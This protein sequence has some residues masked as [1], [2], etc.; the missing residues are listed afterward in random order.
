MRKLSRMAC[1]RLAHQVLPKSPWRDSAL[2][3]PWAAMGSE[4]GGNER[5]SRT[6]FRY[7]RR[8]IVL[9]PDRLLAQRKQVLELVV[10][11]FGQPVFL[12]PHHP[13]GHLLLPLDH[14]V[15]PLLDR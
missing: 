7:R 11:K 5:N 14:L 1:Q 2:M 10:G 3:P 9:L 13:G 4:R 15:D 6:S 12:R 8:R